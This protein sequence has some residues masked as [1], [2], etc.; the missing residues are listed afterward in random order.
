MIGNSM[1]EN[2]ITDSDIVFECP[3][4][5]KSMAIESKG[6]GRI[7]TCP[8]CRHRVVVPD[9]RTGTQ[10]AVPETPVHYT[11]SD[12]K[13]Q[14]LTT[15]LKEL[16]ARRKYLEHLRSENL[17]RFR[18]LKDELAVIQQALDRINSLFVDTEFE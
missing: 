17:S 12:L 18:S 16:T 7:V 2:Q 4:C 8:R 9:D 3:K 5:G 6:A 15:S 13:I 14:Q 1:T 10:P 11:E